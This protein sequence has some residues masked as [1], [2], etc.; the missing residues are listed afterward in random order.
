MIIYGHVKSNVNIRTSPSTATTSNIN[1]SVYANQTFEG[2][3]YV[4]DSGGRKWVILTKVNG[5]PV[6]GKYIASFVTAVVIDREIEDAA[7]E[8]IA[9]TPL[10]I[11]VVEEF[12]M[13]DGKIVTRTTVWENPQVTES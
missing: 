4:T 13:E 10:R 8:D 6:Y 12:R 11:R 2:S 9:G 7:G 1:G 3:G 5:V